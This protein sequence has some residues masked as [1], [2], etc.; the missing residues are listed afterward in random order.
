MMGAERD[1]EEGGQ[2][3]IIP[4]ALHD[5]FALIE[6]ERE[7]DAITRE[8]DGMQS[9]WSIT[10]SYLEVYNEQIRDLLQPSRRHLS[11]RE[12]PGKRVQTE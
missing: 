9:D 12:D 4:H 8:T 6:K 3:G 2:G 7:H 11:L 10:V 1:E 5:V